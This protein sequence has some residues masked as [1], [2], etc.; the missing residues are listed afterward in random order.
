MK[1][2]TGAGNILPKR[3]PRGKIS[4]FKFS[5]WAETDGWPPKQVHGCIFDEIS[6][7]R[8]EA[9]NLPHMRETK[10]AMSTMYSYRGNLD[11]EAM[12][13]TSQCW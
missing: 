6:I 4:P 7:R 5:K 12:L 8:L 9:N 2:L 1:M 13:T 11:S 3:L 10:E